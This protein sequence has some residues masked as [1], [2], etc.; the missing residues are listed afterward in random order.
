MENRLV[1]RLLEVS[2]NDRSPTDNAADAQCG[3]FIS[4]VPR[5]D[6]ICTCNLF[7]KLIHSTI[8]DLFDGYSTC[9]IILMS[10]NVFDFAAELIISTVR[11]RE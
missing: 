10:I 8:E 5:P 2:C 11:M 6:D 4:E 7:S 3:G 9:N 1:Q